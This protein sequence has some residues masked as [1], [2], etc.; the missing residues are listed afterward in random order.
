MKKIFITGVA[1]FIGFALARELLRK[2]Y[3]VYGYDS[4]NSYYD[5]SLKKSRLKILTKSKKFYFSKGKLEN[6]NKLKKI[7]FKFNPHIIMHMGA[8]AG[9][10]YSLKEPRQYI[11]SNII[12]TY[13]IIELSK[14]LKVNHLMIASTSSAYGSN[15][16]T[17]FNEN[18]KAD[19]QISIYAATKKSTENLAHSYSSLWRIPTTMLRFFTVYGPWGRPDMALFK[20]TKLILKGQPIEIYNRGRMYRDFTYIDDVV[21]SVILLA[22]KIP[23]KNKKRIFKNDSISN[24][25]PF[26]VVNIGNQNKVYLM[27]FIKTLEKQLGKKAKK[28]F[29]KMQKGDVKLTLSDTSLL[30]KLTKFKPKVSYKEGIKKFVKWYKSYY[31]FN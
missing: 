19:S 14:E 27:D 6:F 10:R 1:G 18:D 16:K 9:V 25:A 21:K 2:K 5:T 22:N 8:Q 23:K 3:I 13:N 29:L 24:I 20:F 17:P 7:L 31:N 4:M 12:G 26:R 30:K 28:K 15:S 11:N